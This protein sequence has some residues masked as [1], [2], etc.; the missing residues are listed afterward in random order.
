M[1]SLKAPRVTN[2][3]ASVEV[4]EGEACMVLALTGLARGE[5]EIE[6]MEGREGEGWME[7]AA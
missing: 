1:E 2:V 5:V 6:E 7:D 4:L 3:I